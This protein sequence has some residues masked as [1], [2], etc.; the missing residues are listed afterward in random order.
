MPNVNNFPSIIYLMIILALRIAKGNIRRTKASLSERNTQKL[1]LSKR[2][3]NL[4]K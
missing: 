1:N 2:Y 4:L 3:Q